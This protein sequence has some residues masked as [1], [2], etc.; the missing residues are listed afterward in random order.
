MKDGRPRLS[1]AKPKLHPFRPSKH[2][3]SLYPSPA[4][5]F[6]RTANKS[7]P[8]ECISNRLD[9]TREKQGQDGERP[10]FELYIDQLESTA[11]CKHEGEPKKAVGS[12]MRDE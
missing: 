6:L 11:L 1:R 8:T 10:T 3:P 4:T 9:M 2:A 12:R 5:Q 7:L